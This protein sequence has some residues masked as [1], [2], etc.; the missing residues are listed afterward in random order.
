MS[1]M[2]AAKPSLVEKRVT[3]VIA[4]DH[5]VVRLGLR[6]LLDIH[7]RIV[8]LG[9][10]ASGSETVALVESAR[11]DVVL[12]DLRMPG[13]DGLEICRRLKL[14]RTA[15]A[16]IFLT[17]YADDKTILAAIEAGADGYLLKAMAGQDIP[18][19]ILTVANGGSV[20]DPAVTRRLLSAVH[21]SSADDERKDGGELL[22]SLTVQETRVVELVAL[23]KSNKQI[24]HDLRLREGTVR[25][26]LSEAFAK[27]GVASRVEAALMWQRQTRY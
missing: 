21:P 3:V 16:I 2:N 9:E 15:P 18:S 26:D 24:A 12:L 25:N 20:L 22:K 10:T 11:P 8:V 27:L 13:M 4:D 19:A 1:P 23:A 14:Q 17:S 5:V 6:A 7:P